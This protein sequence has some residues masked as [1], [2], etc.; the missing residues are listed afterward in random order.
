MDTSRKHDRK[1][2]FDMKFLSHIT[3]NYE[4]FKKINKNY[5]K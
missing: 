5:F 4:L 2:D 1:N 3:D